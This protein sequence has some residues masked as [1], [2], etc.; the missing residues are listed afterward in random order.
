[1]S[2]KKSNNGRIVSKKGKGLKEKVRSVDGR[3]GGEERIENLEEWMRSRAED[4]MIDEDGRRM[5][6]KIM[7]QNLMT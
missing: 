7:R 2:G 5:E 1:M 4:F 6:N 3:D